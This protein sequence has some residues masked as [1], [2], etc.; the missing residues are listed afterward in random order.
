[1]FIKEPSRFDKSQSYAS[2]AQPP[3]VCLTVVGDPLMDA[4]PML[5]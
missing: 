4:G 5:K 3:V 1:M 2:K